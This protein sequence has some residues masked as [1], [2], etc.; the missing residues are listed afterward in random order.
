M[1]G[2][3]WLEKDKDGKVYVCIDKGDGEVS[4][5]EVTNVKT[6]KIKQ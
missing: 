1:I 3:V 2:D 5:K 6:N 4:R